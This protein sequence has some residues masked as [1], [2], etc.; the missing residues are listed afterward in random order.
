MSDRPDTETPYLTALIRR[1]H[2]CLRAGFEPTIPTSERTRIRALDRTARWDRRFL[3]LLP[4][5]CRCI[6][7]ETAAHCTQTVALDDP[8]K[9]N[10]LLD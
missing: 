10:I 8:D 6:T 1:K 7:T 9:L 5:K 4:P 2:P 3:Y